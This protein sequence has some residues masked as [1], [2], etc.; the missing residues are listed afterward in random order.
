MGY[1]MV[2]QGDYSYF[3]FLEAGGYEVGAS[4]SVSKEDQLV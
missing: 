3:M 1:S 2:T 4:L